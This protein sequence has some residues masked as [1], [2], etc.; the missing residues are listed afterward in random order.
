MG[1]MQQMIVG[2]L[3]NVIIYPLFHLIRM[4]QVGDVKTLVLSTGRYTT[5]QIQLRLA[6]MTAAIATWLVR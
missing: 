6:G 5:R 2:I 1:L 3:P 4:S